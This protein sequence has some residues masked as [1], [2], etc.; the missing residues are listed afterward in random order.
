MRLF[1][2]LGNGSRLPVELADTCDHVVGKAEEFVLLNGRSQDL[3]SKKAVFKVDIKQ[4]GS[5]WSSLLQA[6]VLSET[7][8]VFQVYKVLVI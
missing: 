4:L 3:Y 7:S 8:C 2:G 6:L 1:H 5:Q